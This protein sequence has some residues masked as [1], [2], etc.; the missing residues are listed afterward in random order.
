MRN[1]EYI[2]PN[3]QWSTRLEP[4]TIDIEIIQN[5]KPHGTMFSDLLQQSIGGQA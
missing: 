5:A 2:A 4:N 1:L 3:N